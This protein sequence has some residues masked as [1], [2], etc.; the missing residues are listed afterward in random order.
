MY[1]SAPS[2]IRRSKINS[3]G[4]DDENRWHNNGVIPSSFRALISAPAFRI[5]SIICRQM[6][7]FSSFDHL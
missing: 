2:E 7:S 5:F 6:L 3:S 4:V 1:K